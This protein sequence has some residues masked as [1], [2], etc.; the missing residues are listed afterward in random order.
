MKEYAVKNPDKN[1]KIAHIDAQKELLMIEG[2]KA[3]S[4]I[5]LCL[6]E[7]AVCADNEALALGEQKLAECE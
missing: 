2:Y 7:T 3:M 1:S 5:N 4:R 6:A